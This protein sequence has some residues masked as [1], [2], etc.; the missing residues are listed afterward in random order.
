MKRTI[1]EHAARFDQMASSYDANDRPIY[2]ACANRVI[3]AARP[4]ETDRVLDIG[5][6]TGAIAIA[7]A[8]DAEEVVGRDISSGMLAKAKQKAAAGG[9]DNV[10]FDT[11]RFCD[12]QVEGD[13]DIVTSNYALHHLSDSKKH[14][15]ISNIAS[16][17]PKRFVLGDL[18]FFEAPETEEPDYDPAVDDPATVGT[19][20]ESITSVGFEITSVERMS[21]QAGVIVSAEPREGWSS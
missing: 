18:M 14:D 12:P 8:A 19:L 15:A 10:G 11:G 2:S 20:V 7:L 6:G 17:Q 5:T 13:V 1:E 4:A 16:F 3:E 21:D 9:I